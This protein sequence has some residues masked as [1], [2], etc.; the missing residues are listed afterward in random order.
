MSTDTEHFL[1][2]FAQTGLLATVSSTGVASRL[3]LANL[4]LLVE[5]V[6]CSAAEFV[7]SGFCLLLSDIQSTSSASLVF[8]A[9][10]HVH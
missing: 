2:E 1:S 6:G 4:R 8:L 5:T 10:V 9:S 3:A 7:V